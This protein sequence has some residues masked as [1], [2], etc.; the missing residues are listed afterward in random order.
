MFSKELS[1]RRRFLKQSFAFSASAAM[2]GPLSACGGGTFGIKAASAQPEVADL[3]MLGDWGESGD[4]TD[5]T[6]IAASMQS[7]A[8]L[9]VIHTGALL[10][11]GDNFYGPLTGGVD[12]TR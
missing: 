2:L 8:K 11:L 9:H 7:Y 12:S 10:M 3:F 4:Y 1:S 5:Q 6:T